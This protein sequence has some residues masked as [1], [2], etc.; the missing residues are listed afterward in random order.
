VRVCAWGESALKASECAYLLAR[1]CRCWRWGCCCFWWWCCA[2]LPHAGQR[3]DCHDPCEMHSRTSVL[4]SQA[5]WR[6]SGPVAR[7][8]QGV[9]WRVFSGRGELSE[10]I[11]RQLLDGQHASFLKSRWAPLQ[12]HS[13][14]AGK[15]Q[16][17]RGKCR[18]RTYHMHARDAREKASEPRPWPTKPRHAQ[19]LQ[20]CR[21]ELSN[22]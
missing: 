3:G 2:L 14:H 19:R 5:S 13:T 22:D 10:L 11:E 20:V 18:G 1:R 12:C 9:A 17:A 6:W 15:Q 4:E 16:H 8:C 21:R 7:L